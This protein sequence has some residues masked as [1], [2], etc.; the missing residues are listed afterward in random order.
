MDKNLVDINLELSKGYA[1]D[2]NI[3][4]YKITIVKHDNET[5]GVFY[6]H[7]KI[8]ELNSNNSIFYRFT[9]YGE[10]FGTRDFIYDKVTSIK[11]ILGVLLY[12]DFDIIDYDN[13]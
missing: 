1:I 10:D 11:Q 6:K 12:H 9:F 5:L 7:V 8:G 2:L 13:Y 3:L 4:S